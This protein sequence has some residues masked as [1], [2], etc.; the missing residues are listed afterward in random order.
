MPK[1]RLKAPFLGYNTTEQKGEID[2]RESPDM[3]NVD[4]DR[5]TIRCRPGYTLYI[6]APTTPIGSLFEWHDIIGTRIQL[7][8]TGGGALYN[9]SSGA[10]VA[11]TM[12]GGLSV[13][14]SALEWV[15]YKNRAYFT[16]ASPG[17]V[18]VTDGT[19]AYTAQI[20]RPAAPTVATGSAGVLTGTY[21]YKITYYSSTWGQESPSSDASSSVAPSSEQIDLSVIPTSTDTRVT[22]VRIYRRKITTNE[23][24]WTFVKEISNG[25]STVSD[26]TRD[27]DLEFTT[28]A[29]L[30]FTDTLP[31]FDTMATQAGVVFLGGRDRN[32]IFYSRPNQP[33]NV[34]GSVDVGNDA[35]VALRAAQGVIYVFKKRSIWTLSGNSPS[36]FFARRVVSGIGSI[37]PNAIV[38][39]DGLFYF[40]GEK[41]AY[42]FDG[43][44][45]PQEISRPI[46]SRFQSLEAVNHLANALEDPGGRWI[47]WTFK[48]VDDFPYCYVYFN[49][50]S[51]AV[52]RPVWARW[53]FKGDFGGSPVD[54]FAQTAGILTTTASGAEK[55]ELF[56]YFNTLG[57]DD[58]Q[59]LVDSTEVGGTTDGG[60]SI[61]MQWL[62][63][64]FDGE[65]PERFKKWGVVE[66]VT[67]ALSGMSVGYR[68]DGAASTTNVLTTT[69][70]EVNRGRISRSSKG[71]QI[72]LDDAAAAG[73]EVFE[74]N[75]DANIAGRK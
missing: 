49:R 56:I 36:T 38:Q 51:D 74:M 70:S 69:A 22:D 15:K 34:E 26:N 17:G 57:G 67:N 9:I 19:D 18:G 62:T 30:S 54:Q 32:S 3:L 20:T 35:V 27:A 4:L 68:L 71:I 31:A 28:I 61:Q 65:I 23:S 11:I 39:Q 64:E 58:L 5:G 7:M 48:D 13:G 55:Q 8:N 21:D 25:S 6:A 52:G 59:R 14:N 46:R 41:G 40:Q 24:L 37:A 10:A 1:V 66:V 73:T 33:W 72:D 53:L 42:V 60:S 12:N 50:L 75:I 63:K 2:E 45:V 44:A 29:P 43:S 16:G 47:A